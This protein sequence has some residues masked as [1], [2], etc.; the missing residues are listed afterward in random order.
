M[1]VH[2]GERVTSSDSLASGGHFLCPSEA[3]V[4]YQLL[5]WAFSV[6]MQS[7]PCTLRGAEQRR[8][9][10]GLEVEPKP[11]K[12]DHGFGKVEHLPSEGKCTPRVSE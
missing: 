3:V 12:P 10:T 4:C 6:C 11:A 8:Q 7:W 2:P 9:A 5:H 1:Y